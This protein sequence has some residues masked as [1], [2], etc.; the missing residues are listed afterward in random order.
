MGARRM[1]LK[2]LKRQSVDYEKQPVAVQGTLLLVSVWMDPRT[3]PLG[4]GEM[5]E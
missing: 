4:V 3:V 1:Y 2:G 5:T